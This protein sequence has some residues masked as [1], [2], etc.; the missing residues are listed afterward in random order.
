MTPLKETD[1]IK[2]NIMK[3]SLAGLLALLAASCVWAQE[4]VINDPVIGDA[5]I[6]FYT[7]K[8][9]LSKEKTVLGL[10]YLGGKWG[11]EAST[12]LVADGK[13]YALREGTMFSRENGKVVKSQPLEMG[14]MYERDCDSVSLVFEPLPEKCVVFDFV[15]S[16]GSI[17]NHYGIR[18]DGKNYESQLGKAQPYPFGKNDPLPALEPKVAKA[19]LTVNLH[20]LDGTLEPVNAFM[21]DQKLSGDNLVKYDQETRGWVMED[22]RACML[23]CMGCP[24]PVEPVG[25][26]QFAVMMVPG[27]ETTLEL[28]K[29]SCFALSKKLGKKKIPLSDCFR[30]TGPI[31]DLQE[32]NL[33]ERWTYQSIFRSAAATDLWPNLQKKLAEIEKDRTLNRRQKEFLRIRTERWYVN[34]YL[35]YVGAGSLSLQ[36]E[37][38]ADLIYGKDG[39]SFY[40]VGDDAHL[41][42]LRANGVKSVVTDWMEGFRR[43]GN[44]ARRLQN[45]EQMPE[46]AFDT[47]PALFRSELKAMNDSVGAILERQKAMAGKSEVKVTPDVPAEEFLKAVVSEY[48]GKVVFFDFWATWCGPCKRGIQ[49]MEPLKAEYADKPIQ[50]VYVTNES[51]PLTTWSAM[52]TGMPGVHYRINSAYWK[53]IKELGTGA[54]PRYLIYGKDGQ[55]FYEQTGFGTID[56]LKDKIDE[57]LK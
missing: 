47:I 14:K 35:A 6:R 32:V 55:L 29:A 49:A 30:F 7:R 1:M 18:L 33:K 10:R 4:K 38:A 31:A 13:E 16:E 53:Q 36:D 12:H 51:S 17:F 39:R 28:D 22:S 26:D 45:M 56:K 27:F 25:V 11:I 52:I 15:E 9:V 41:N 5:N 40:L 19:K 44:M 37:H 8:V 42:Y 24:I 23:Q 57:A 3:R 43:A 20:K 48:P 21:M 34:A 50:Y 46:A 54:I 2:R